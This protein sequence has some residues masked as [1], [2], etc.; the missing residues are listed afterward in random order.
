MSYIGLGTRGPVVGVPDTTGLNVGNWTVTLNEAVFNTSMP[1]FECYRITL[2]G[3]PNSHFT[4]NID[5]KQ[6]EVS[7]PGSNNSWEGL[8]PMLLIPGNIVYFLFDDP[9]SDGK[10]P[11]VTVWLRY[12][13]SIPANAAQGL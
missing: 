1:F 2:T 13:L 11:S 10:P 8:E 6:W 9:V 3:A 4:M 12:D 7:Q 5:Q